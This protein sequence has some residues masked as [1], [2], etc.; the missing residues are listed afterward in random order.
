[1]HPDRTGGRIA[2]LGKEPDVPKSEQ[3]PDQM[4]D[5]QI[6]E[7]FA[8]L[9]L[10]AEQPQAPAPVVQQ[11]SGPVVFYTITGDSPPLPAR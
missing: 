6:R 1:M 10:P 3:A 7:V 5:E 8:T 9:R 2:P 4:S 11:V